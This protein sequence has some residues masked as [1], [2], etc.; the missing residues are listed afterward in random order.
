MYYLA[1]E[2]KRKKIIG[3][4]LI[5]ISCTFHASLFGLIPFVVY[6]LS[7]G[8]DIIAIRKIQIILIVFAAIFIIA[9]IGEPN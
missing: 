4:G 8:K 9:N 3:I 1:M 7:F 2:Q 6:Y 5:V